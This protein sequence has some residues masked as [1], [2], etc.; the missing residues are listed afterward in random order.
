MIRSILLALAEAPY[1]AS[2]KSYAFWLAKKEDS[3]IHALAVIDIATFEAP[4][5]G[6]ADGLMPSVV[7]PPLKDSQSLMDDLIAAAKERLDRFT[8]QCAARG[9]P[10]ST[11]PV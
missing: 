8:A 4:V 9:I 2:A 1:D 5:L 10:S 3:H 6:S 7:T 11:E